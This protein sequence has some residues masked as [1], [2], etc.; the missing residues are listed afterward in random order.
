MSDAAP[1]NACPVINGQLHIGP[2]A[3]GIGARRIAL[4]EAIGT[5]GSL[6]RAAQ[7]VGLSYKGAWD[8]INAINNLADTPLV[9]R[10]TGG[11]RGGGTALTERGAALVRT[12]RAAEAEQQRFLERLNRRLGT[13]SGDDLNLMER[14]AMQSS[15]RNQLYGT[16]VALKRASVNTEVSVELAGG[17][18][19]AAVITTASADNLALAEGAPVVA[20]IKASWLIVAA[21]DLSTARLSSR[22]RLVGTVA[23]IT[24]DTVASELTLCL[25]GGSHLAATVTRDSA[26]ELG[27]AE[28]DT[29]TALFKASSVILAAAD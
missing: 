24:H 18:R 14:L 21:G 3:G 15:A 19:L 9:L 13:L 5:S 27:L 22:N 2:K 8:A 10:S 20:L 23:G 12:Y 11:A 26:D 6:T 28:G 1:D 25:A 29:A 16:V 7:S 4:L 17:D